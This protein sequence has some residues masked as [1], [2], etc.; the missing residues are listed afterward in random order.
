MYKRK[1][2]NIDEVGNCE[3]CGEHYKLHEYKGL[4]LCTKCEYAARFIDSGLVGRYLDL[5]NL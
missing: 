1:Y 4:K 2:G 3:L 5:A